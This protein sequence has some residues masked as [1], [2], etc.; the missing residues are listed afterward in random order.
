M[1]QIYLTA[2]SLSIG[3]VT[4]LFAQ[5]IVPMAAIAEENDA[6]KISV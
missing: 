5:A 6:T 4:P 2:V 3:L 1:K